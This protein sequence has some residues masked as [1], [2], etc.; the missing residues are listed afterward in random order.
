MSALAIGQGQASFLE[1]EI[2]TNM[3]ELK[4]YKESD[5]YKR[6]YRL[7]IEELQR[8]LN[9]YSDILYHIKTQL[10]WEEGEIDLS[11]W[12]E[13]LKIPLKVEDYDED[14][15]DINSKMDLLIGDI[16]QVGGF[17]WNENERHYKRVNAVTGD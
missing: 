10:L 17:A 6:A 7:K 8:I 4:I 9:L 2:D 3:N 12:E 14:L 16:L 5:G 1:R 15:S 11:Y 13:A